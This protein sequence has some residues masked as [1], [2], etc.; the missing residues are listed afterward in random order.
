MIK[1]KFFYLLLIITSLLGCTNGSE[2]E[3]KSMECFMKNSMESF[4]IEPNQCVIISENPDM[5]LVLVGFKN[6]NKSGDMI[7]ETTVTVRLEEPN[8][9]WETPHVI[10]DD[11]NTEIIKFTGEILTG[12][13]SDSYTI[14]VDDIGFTETES[15]FIFHNATLRVGYTSK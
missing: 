13:N 10:Q 1:L 15:E 11:P 4:V 6:L 9:T 5:K 12:I 3:E 14:Y 2:P 8:F 7:N